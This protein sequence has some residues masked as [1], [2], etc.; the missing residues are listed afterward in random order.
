M[1]HKPGAIPLRPLVLSDIFDGAL[2][3]HPLQ[4][5]G[6]IGAALLVSAV[7]MAVPVIVGLLSGS[8]GG[9]RPTPPPVTSVTASS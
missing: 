5:A 8:T 2:P 7:A 3:H 1:A 9:F 6:T 4:P